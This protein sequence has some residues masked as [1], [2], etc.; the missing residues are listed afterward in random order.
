VQVLVVVFTL[1]LALVYVL[2]GMARLQRLPASD[3]VRQRLGLS[4]AL[5]RFVG[6]VELVGA[7]GLVV[8]VL[9][10]PGLAVGA[11]VGLAVMMVAATMVHLRSGDLRPGGV[12]PALLA[13]L[14]ILDAWL[15][16]TFVG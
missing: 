8:G 1:L 13:A 14:C 2:A 15:V 3:A 7:L 6:T 16:Q 12:P 10:I 11:A 4:L 5:W 9:A